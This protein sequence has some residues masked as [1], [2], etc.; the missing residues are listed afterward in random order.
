M[1]MTAPAA[2]CRSCHAEIVWAVTENGKRMPLSKATERRRYVL[3]G[4]ACSSVVTYD[5]HWTD[6]PSAAQHR[7]DR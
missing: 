3:N 2:R 6:C 5:S 7:S 4:D 1:A